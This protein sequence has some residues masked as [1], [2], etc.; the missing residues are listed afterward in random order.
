MAENVPLAFA[1]KRIE[2]I[3]PS[4]AGVSRGIST[5]CHWCEFMSTPP[6]PMLPQFGVPSK[7]ITRSDSASYASRWPHSVSGA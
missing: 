2:M 5:S 7:R 6:P 4:K 3:G 1:R